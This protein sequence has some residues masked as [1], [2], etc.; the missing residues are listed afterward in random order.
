MALDSAGYNASA[1][2]QAKD[3]NPSALSTGLQSAATYNPTQQST[4][5]PTSAARYMGNL[6]SAN[7]GFQDTASTTQNKTSTA[8]TTTPVAQDASGYGLTAS[9]NN[10]L[11]ANYASKLVTAQGVTAAANGQNQQTV[12]P[13]GISSTTLNGLTDYSGPQIVA[14]PVVYSSPR[15]FHPDATA[16]GA[17]YYQFNAATGQYTYIG[18]VDKN[19]RAFGGQPGVSAS[20]MAQATHLTNVSANAYANG[21]GV[22]RSQGA[23]IAYDPA[24]ASALAQWNKANQ[25]AAVNNQATA[26]SNAQTSAQQ[27]ALDYMTTHGGQLSQ[28]QAA[29]MGNTYAGSG[30]ALSQAQ[31]AGIQAAQADYAAQQAHSATLAGLANAKIDTSASDATDRAA[32]LSMISQAASGNAAAQPAHSNLFNAGALFGQNELNHQKAAAQSYNNNVANYNNALSTYASADAQATG[33]QVYSDIQ[34]VQQAASALQQEMGQLTATQQQQV[35]AG[36]DNLNNLTQQY[37]QA[38]Q[39]YGQGS[40]QAIALGRGILQAGAAI[41]VAV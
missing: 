18:A 14:V 4:V 28:Q 5:T 3:Y 24:V 35:Q 34:G 10:Q 38:V 15:A 32:V 22:M 30:A 26:V 25:T 37:Q 19:N 31:Q 6:N 8:P 23:A 7:T 29:T 27:Q 41:A 12:N 17:A 36:I 33:N 1:L 11:F 21:D 13:G 40:A 2:F 20:Q 9:N 16:T 39:A